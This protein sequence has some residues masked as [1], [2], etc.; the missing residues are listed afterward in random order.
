MKVGRILYTN[1]KPFFFEWPET[2]PLEL[3]DGAPRQLAEAAERGEIIAAPLPITECWKLE[4]KFEPLEN[5]GIAVKEASHS[6]FLLSRVPLTHL[7]GKTI[8]VTHESS[9]SVR[10]LQ[11]LTETKHAHINKFK[12]GFADDDDAWLVIGDQALKFWKSTSPQWACR[13][14]LA[15]EWWAWQ[16]RPFVFAQWVV[17]KDLDP[18]LR[19]Q[20]VSQI[21]ISL[22]KGLASLRAISEQQ[23][24]K[25]GIPASSLKMYLEG[26]RYVLGEDEKN[27]ILKFR[28]LAE[29][30]T[31][32]TEVKVA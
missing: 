27:S 1:T 23:V 19:Q 11:V 18:D 30:F 31:E 20:L 16:K 9:T 15:S 7:N 10:L 5:W 28:Q 6:V 13:T 8:G 22:Q 32:P 12:R 17:R 14:D 3:L 21:K 29:K 2:G 4:D 26:F 25:L 24:E